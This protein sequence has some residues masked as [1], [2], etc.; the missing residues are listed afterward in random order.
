[1]AG[2]VCGSVQLARLS[3]H[4]GLDVGA[5]GWPGDVAGSGVPGPSSLRRLA[6]ALGLHTADVFAIA[7]VP[8]PDDLAPVDRSAGV[9]VPGLARHAM[10]LSPEDRNSVRRLMASLRHEKHA[11]AAPALPTHEN[12]PAGPG[13]MLMR[14][15]RNRNLGWNSAAK[16]FLLVTGR[17]WSAATYGMVGHGRREL[18]PEL[19]VDFSAVLGILADD[20]SV[21]T[22]VALPEPPDGIPPLDLTAAEVAELIWDTRRLTAAQVRRVGDAAESLR[23]D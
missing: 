8:V 3:E 10:H 19:L 6:P 20:L 17:Y 11:S 13:A 14:L 23:M 4:R 7:D 12:Y 2:Y 1:M 5:P 22:G 9:W 15:V 16:T 21:L 18:T